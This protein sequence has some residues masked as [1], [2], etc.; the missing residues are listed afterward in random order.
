MNST[1]K[2]PT[3]RLADLVLVAHLVLTSG[4]GGPPELGDPR[5]LRSEVSEAP[6]PVGPLSK[7]SYL[8]ELTKPEPGEYLCGKPIVFEGSLTLA[9]GE[10]PPSTLQVLVRQGKLNIDS[11][12]L[13]P[14]GEEGARKC[15][16]KGEIRSPSKKGTYQIVLM[17]IKTVVY[18]PVG[19]EAES[20]TATV[21]SRP[22]V[23]RMRERP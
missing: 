3:I 8:L 6:V 19:K 21:Y 15:T 10:K 16:F 2:S 20:R 11:K 14:K 22:T 18:A 23:I 13:E 4:C 7:P 12:S 1:I 9:D 5:L 17:A